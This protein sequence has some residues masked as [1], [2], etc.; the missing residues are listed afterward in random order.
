MPHTLREESTMDTTRLLHK[1]LPALALALA[2]GACGGGG[3]GGDDSSN[4][5]SGDS[6]SPPTASVVSCFTAGS[7]VNFAILSSNV[8]AGMVGPASSTTGPMTDDSGQAVT[9]QMFKYTG[10][11]ITSD[12]VYWK[13]AAG[14]VT[15]VG[16][17]TVAA[18]GNP[19][20]TPINL[21]LPA[22][23]S[24][25]QSAGNMTLI[26][27]ETITLAGKTFANTCHFKTPNDERWYAQGY[28]M[29]KQTASGAT[30][31]YNGGESGGTQAAS[32]T[33]C[34]TADKTV[35]SAMTTFGVPAGAVGVNRST[36]GPMTYKGQAVTG[37]T[38]FYPDGFSDTTYWTVESNGVT[39]I[40]YV[41][42][43]GATISGSTFFPQNMS[44]G[45]T[46][47]TQSDYYTLVG[48]DTFSLAGKTFSNACHFKT[49][50]GDVWY[51]SGYGN[52]KQIISGVTAQY[53]G[54]R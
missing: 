45:Q 51:A 21:T 53:N 34:F 6:T 32:I 3:G 2:L 28:G 52:I 25:G 26:G 47:T 42:S 43:D 19:S 44:I 36:V 33:A 10:A 35:N 46:V 54:D 23:M 39:F 41:N 27:F 5:N 38:F 12:T 30:Y 18:S 17:L 7:T 16:E 11:S 40:A 9:G 13:V 15:L 49:S 20:L 24:A 29:V 22:G 8:P 31:Q 50:T 14:G 1:T 48:F 37:Q 4:G